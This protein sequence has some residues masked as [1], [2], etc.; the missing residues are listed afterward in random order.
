ML[1]TDRKEIKSKRD[2]CSLC[3]AFG[4]WCGYAYKGKPI[5]DTC[6]L[7]AKWVRSTDFEAR[8]DADTERA[9]GVA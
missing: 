5:C 2:T 4:V 7:R 8:M 3:S 9:Q 1:L 6:D